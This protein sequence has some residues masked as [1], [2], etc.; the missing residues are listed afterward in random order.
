M[1][2]DV[3]DTESFERLCG[4]VPKT[5][6]TRHFHLF[7]KVVEL[8]RRGDILNAFSGNGT[9][10]R[11]CGLNKKEQL[12]T[13]DA[14]YMAGNQL[15]R[16]VLLLNNPAAK[17]ALRRWL[18]AYDTYFASH[19][20]GVTPV[21]HWKLVNDRAALEAFLAAELE[22]HHFMIGLRGPTREQWAMEPIPGVPALVVPAPDVAQQELA[23]NDTHV[24]PRKRRRSTSS[25]PSIVTPKRRKD[26]APQTSG[27]AQTTPVAAS[28]TSLGGRRISAPAPH[29]RKATSATSSSSK[30]ASDANSVISISDTEDAIPISDTDDVIFISDS[31]NDQKPEKVPQLVTKRSGDVIDLT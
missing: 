15:V 2:D 3:N 29:R 21:V 14:S 17:R 5:R 19:G 12:G 1:A 31:D 18:A 26:S 30:P 6:G 28:R 7:R 10:M 23:G 9:P 25:L 4:Y 8:H 22:W 16:R 13:L 27:S 11:A 24:T 20:Q